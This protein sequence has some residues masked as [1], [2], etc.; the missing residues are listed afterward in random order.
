MEFN[1]KFYELHI[2]II[3]LLLYT[4]SHY[5]LLLGIYRESHTN[6]KIN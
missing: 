2:S 3:T 4:T 6:G 5:L 1:Y